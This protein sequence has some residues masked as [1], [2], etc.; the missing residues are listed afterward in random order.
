MTLTGL[1][2]WLGPVLM[3]LYRPAALPLHRAGWLLS[4]AKFLIIVILVSN[5]L[6]YACVKNQIKVMEIL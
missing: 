3:S 4:R 1:K 2:T 6:H 5:I